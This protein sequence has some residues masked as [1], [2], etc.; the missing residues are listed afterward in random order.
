MLNRTLDSFHFYCSFIYLFICCCRLRKSNLSLHLVSRSFHF[1]FFPSN[2][3]SSRFY[4]T[5]TASYLYC[6]VHVYTLCLYVH[7]SILIVG[8][9]QKLCIYS[10]MYRTIP[11]TYMRKTHIFSWFSLAY[12][13]HTFGR[14]CFLLYKV[15]K[16]SRS[17][18]CSI[19]SSIS[20]IQST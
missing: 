10:Y 7:H 1:E 3:R 8:S 13:S 2:W 18:D 15:I 19:K 16:N 14:S 9:I 12:G 11:T 4:F 17:C 6:I 20:D 5:P